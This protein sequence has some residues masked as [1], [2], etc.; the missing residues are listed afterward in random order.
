MLNKFIILY[1]VKYIV[2]VTKEIDNFFPG[3]FTYHNIRVYDEETTDLMKH[4]EEAYRFISNAK[5]VTNYVKYKLMFYKIL[6]TS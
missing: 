4:W 1:R 5:L 2:N 3:Q 6:F